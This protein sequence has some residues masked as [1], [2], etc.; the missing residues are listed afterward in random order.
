MLINDVLELLPWAAW[1]PLTGSRSTWC[2][3]DTHGLRSTLLDSAWCYSTAPR[4]LL[5]GSS[6]APRRLPDGSPTAQ[7]RFA[8]A[9]WHKMAWAGSL[10]YRTGNNYR[11]SLK[12]ETMKMNGKVTSK[13]KSVE[14]IPSFKILPLIS[15]SKMNQLMIKWTQLNLIMNTFKVN[16]ID[17]EVKCVPIVSIGL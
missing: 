10:G 14:S 8:G 1:R 2:F 4:R 12:S 17:S 3:L 6:T 7:Q 11:L 5:D 15:N 9:P 16:Q 13:W